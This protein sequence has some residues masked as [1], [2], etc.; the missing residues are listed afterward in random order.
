M[1]E[2]KFRHCV[3]LHGFSFIPCHL[4]T[5][6]SGTDYFKKK[7]RI[8]F[9]PISVLPCKAICNPPINRQDFFS[10]PS[11]LSQSSDIFCPAECDVNAIVSVPNLD[12]KPLAQFYSW[13]QEAMQLLCEKDQLSFG[14]MRG[15]RSVTE[16]AFASPSS[17][18][19]AAVSSVA[20]Q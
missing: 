14:R 16:V 17:T 1:K 12:H 10:V 4:A 5:Q 18:T 13:P 9:L 8:I 15:H 11:N 19:S 6:D 3:L 7:P 2:Q 20:S